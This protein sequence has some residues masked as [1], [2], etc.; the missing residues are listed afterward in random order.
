[1]LIIC[2]HSDQNMTYVVIGI[3]LIIISLILNVSGI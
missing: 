3:L 1:M 2:M